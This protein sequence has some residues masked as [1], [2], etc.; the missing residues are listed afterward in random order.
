MS[1]SP[2][3]K[4]NFLIGSLPKVAENTASRR[5]HEFD[6]LRAFAM[7][8]GVFFHA[9]LSFVDP[10]VEH[11]LIQDQSHHQL[12]WFPLLLSQGFRM[13]V[14]FFMAGFFGH[15][16][17]EKSGA[18]EFSRN[19]FKRILLPFIGGLIIVVPLMH[20]AWVYGYD[21]EHG[22]PEG[23]TYLGH[24]IHHFRDGGFVRRFSPAHLW[25]L[26]DLLIFYAVFLVIRL[27]ANEK[28]V[29]GFSD[30]LNRWV[31]AGFARV[32]RVVIISLPSAVFLSLSETGG[33]LRG[34]TFFPDPWDFCYLLTFF[35]AGWTFYLRRSILDDQPRGMRR[36]LGAAL[37]L[38]TA[39][40][41]VIAL[42]ENAVLPRAFDSLGYYF[43]AAYAWLMIFGL[44]RLF[45]R[46]GGREDARIRYLTDASYWIYLMHLPLV[47]AFQAW[48]A[49]VALWGG[50]KYLGICSV[51]LILLLLT[52]HGFVRYTALGTILHGQ[53]QRPGS[54]GRDSR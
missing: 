47:A 6:C 14:F 29:W 21:V 52:Y 13:P 40:F 26:Q 12:V 16:V 49:P 33:R 31:E 37:V 42:V 10:K 5:Y 2:V 30:W 23:A 1:K 53:R 3:A 19:R 51:S 44:L 50:F 54:G 25:F 15:L 7:I 41:V 4:E 36:F 32:S 22:R 45:G 18:W 17:L 9:G 43:E 11:W 46:F 28:L 27:A 24:V 34:S 38:G 48:L 8:L 20:L 35:L 39:R